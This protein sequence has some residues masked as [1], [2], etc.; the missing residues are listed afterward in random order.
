MNILLIAPSSGHWRGLGKKKYFNGKTFRF[1]ML[2]LCLFSLIIGSC[3]KNST[4][5]PESPSIV[6]TWKITKTAS[7]YQGVVETYDEN[8]LNEMGVVWIYQFNDDHTM[9]LTTNLSGPLITIT[10]TW[11]VSEN[12]LTM[13]TT[14][15]T[16]GTATSM[17]IYSIVGNILKL[18]WQNPN[19]TKCNYEFT[20]Q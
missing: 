11:Q 12:K 16:G 8:Q 3:D 7:E 4:E 5:P 15:P 20:K 6:G 9:E 19:G 14:G 10:G 1:S 13:T 17:Y 2:S 18:N